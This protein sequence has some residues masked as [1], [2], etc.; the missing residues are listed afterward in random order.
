MHCVYFITFSISEAEFL[1]Y[2]K[3]NTGYRKTISVTIR[4]HDRLGM[5]SCL[6]AA[7]NSGWLTRREL[8]TR[9][10][11]PGPCLVKRVLF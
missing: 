4:N 9:A 5:C 10:A 2:N 3:K 1:K 8:R 6:I 7:D 11:A